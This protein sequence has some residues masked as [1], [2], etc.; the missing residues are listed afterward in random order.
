M[1][2]RDRYYGGHSDTLSGALVTARADDLWE[3]IRLVQAS[4]GSVAAPFDCWL[5]HRGIASLPCRLRQHTH[6]AEMVAAFLDSH[7]RVEAT[8]YPGLPAH[9]GHDVAAR[10][11]QLFGGM[12]S[13]QV[14]GSAADALAVAGRLRD[15]FERPER[16]HLRRRE[17]GVSRT[18]HAAAGAR[19]RPR[20]GPYAGL[21]GG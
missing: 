2:I 9:P 8:H 5:V 19:G 13:F 3:R 17:P 21:F 4:V 18:C 16:R 1:C 10:Q 11:M 12:V 15:R 6:N 20:R 14:Q 7:A